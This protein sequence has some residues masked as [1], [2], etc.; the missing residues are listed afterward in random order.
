MLLYI[1]D[2][3]TNFVVII[4]IFIGLLI[5]LWKVTKVVDIRIDRNN[6]IGGV[7]PRI[8]F[9]DQPSY[10]QSS[11]KIYDKVLQRFVWY[12]LKHGPIGS[13]MVSVCAIGNA[14]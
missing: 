8:Q 9:R 7:I 5:E 1:L 10:V 13:T 4:S 6:L 3:E 2:N 11:T 14:S 12:I